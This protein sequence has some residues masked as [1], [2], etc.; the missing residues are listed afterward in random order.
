MKRIYVGD[1]LVELSLMDLIRQRVGS[2][3]E[4]KVYRYGDEVL[5]IYGDFCAKG[6]LDEETAFALSKME[7]KRVLLPQRMIYDADSGYFAGY[8]LSLVE[9]MPK[10]VIPK[11]MMEHFIDELDVVHDDLKFLANQG[12]EVD[13][14]YIGNVLYDG[15]FYI[16]D[17]GEYVIKKESVEGGIYRNNIYTLNRLVK[18]DI[19]GL[20]R[21]GKFR[22]QAVED[23][24]EDFEYIGEQLKETALD[25]ETIKAYV[26]RMT[27]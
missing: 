8:T 20:V 14:F 16:T 13:D 2:G 10:R 12:V 23:R 9:K 1:E 17:P 3:C 21:L 25:G 22:R 6:R 4:A 18:D 27:K 26:K 7:T 15:S 24:F 11:M 19:F 5:K